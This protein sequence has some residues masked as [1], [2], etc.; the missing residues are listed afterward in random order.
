MSSNYKSNR[1]EVKKAIEKTME[2][3]L[4]AIGIAG[5]SWIIP[6]TPIGEYTD[7]RQGGNLRDSNGYKI[8]TKEQSVTFYNTAEYAPY[9]ELGTSK[10]EAQ[11]YL[12]EGIEGNINK[13]KN[14]ASEM[15][16][17]D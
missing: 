5:E 15:M 2:R 10:M 3:T 11:S 1:P 14:L 8:D 16:K 7:G 12:R 9:V 13:I 17:I 6:L 4:E